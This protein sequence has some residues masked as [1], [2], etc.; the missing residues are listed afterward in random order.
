MRAQAGRLAERLSPHVPDPVELRMYLAGA[1]G[2]DM[3][4]SSPPRIAQEIYRRARQRSGV[5]D[6]FRQEKLESTQAALERLPALRRKV[7]LAAD[8]FE[9][10]VRI[11]IAGNIIDFGPGRAFDLETQLEGSLDLPLDRQTLERFR[12][13]L[14]RA[15]NVLYLGDN[16]GEAVLDRLLIE[17]IPAP[18]TYAVRGAPVINDV[19]LA[20]ARLSGLEQVAELISTGS[21]VPG[22]ILEACSPPFRRAFD[23]AD[24]IIS[25]GQ[26]N[27]ESLKGVPAPIYFLL[28]IKC[29]LVA[30]HLKQQVG[31]C[32]LLAANPSS[33]CSAA[34]PAG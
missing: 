7:E 31:G 21:D 24:L 2:D 22:V 6:P 33:S 5:M 4:G 29:E 19:T 11:A 30:S 28:V 27:Y 9:M 15:A 12:S 34:H 25:K 13:E 17:R 26:G 23:A 20:E 1:A 18:V 10:A 14:D 32:A 8:P 3:L 16:A